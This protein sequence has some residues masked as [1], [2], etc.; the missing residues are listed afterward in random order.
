MLCKVAYS[1]EI[2]YTTGKTLKELI[3]ITTRN[4]HIGPPRLRTA[5]QAVVWLGKSGGIISSS[6]IANRVKTHATFVRRIMTSLCKAD[7]I[8][9]KGGRDGGYYLEKT[10]ADIT[11]ADIYLAV[12]QDATPKKDKVEFDYPE[13]EDRLDVAGFQDALETIL[14]NAEDQAIAYLKTITVAQLMAMV[15]MV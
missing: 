4:I 5:V 3:P 6:M 9:S 15:K 11:L 13:G 2:S 7:I 14:G 12:G 1:P 10:P 8:A